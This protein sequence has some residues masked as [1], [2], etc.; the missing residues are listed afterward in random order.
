MPGIIDPDYTGEIAALVHNM[1][2]ETIEV[3]KM[4]RVAQLVCLKYR[5]ANY[6]IVDKLPT[7]Q[8]GSGGFGSTGK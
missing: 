2:D 8:R 4:S 1:T 5:Q 3:P 6:R 7:T